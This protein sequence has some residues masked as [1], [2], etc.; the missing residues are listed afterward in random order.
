[1]ARVGKT[2]TVV[3]VVTAAIAFAV[4]QYG[5]RRLIERS[6]PDFRSRAVLEQ[7]ASE[8]NKKLPMLVDKETEFVSSTGL[9]AVFV[10][11]YRLVNISLA[12]LDTQQLVAAL[13]PRITN[14]ACTTPATRDT[15][16]KKGVTLRYSYADKANAFVTSLDVTPK[17]CGF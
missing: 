15:F 1:M 13:T 7:V 9:D 11:N 4:T 17:D 2:A 3:G 16:L 8:T 6:N 5:V 12:D 14:S 10:Y